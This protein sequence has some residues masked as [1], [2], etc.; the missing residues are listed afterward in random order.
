MKLFLKFFTAMK[1]KT[2][3]HYL[4]GSFHTSPL[5]AAYEK[6]SEIP[7]ISCST[8]SGTAHIG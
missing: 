6:A 5:A 1:K 7:V 3:K 8:P 4:Y 2:N